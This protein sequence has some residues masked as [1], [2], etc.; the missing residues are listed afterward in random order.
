MS[1]FLPFFFLTSSLN[2][3]SPNIDFSSTWKLR[4]QR[5][6]V[7]ALFYFHLRVF[8]APQTIYC[9]LKQNFNYE[10]QHSDWL[11]IYFI[12]KNVEVSVFEEFLG[13]IEKK[14]THIV[15]E[16]KI[17]EIY[18]ICKWRLD[19]A[20]SKLKAIII[21]LLVWDGVEVIWYEGRIKEFST[22]YH[23]TK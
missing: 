8:I 22:L 10:F 23:N 2:F 18:T 13:N 9:T 15:Q 1:L 7:A 11:F 17:N 20:N 3:K 21:L 16:M 4:Y 19:L 6:K 12:K 14:K 5:T